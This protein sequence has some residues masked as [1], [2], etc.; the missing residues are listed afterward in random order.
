MSEGPLYSLPPSP[1]FVQ[2]QPPPW[3]APEAAGKGSWSGQVAVRVDQLRGP[4]SWPPHQFETPKGATGSLSDPPQE[5][6]EKSKFTD[7]VQRKGPSVS[8]RAYPRPF[9]TRSATPHHCGISLASTIHAKGA[10]QTAQAERESDA[11]LRGQ[12]A[13]R[14]SR[15]PCA[16]RRCRLSLS[17]SLF[18][19]SFVCSVAD[20]NPP[21]SPINQS[22]NYQFLVSN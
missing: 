22:H 14:L 5:R 10:R 21:T 1:S 20:E 17:L 4:L 2:V 8:R 3:S 6:G 11:T 16:E 13:L 9:L 7:N 15:P 18:L 12:E 19:S